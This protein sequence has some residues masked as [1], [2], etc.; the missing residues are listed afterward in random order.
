MSTTPA[1]HQDDSPGLAVVLGG[2][3]GIGAALAEG[4]RQQGHEVLA[5][6]RR[7]EPALDY[8]N[9]TSVARV[10][11]AVAAE[12]ARTAA[13]RCAAWWWPPASCTKQ[14]FSPSEAGPTST[15]LRCSACFW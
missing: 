11:Q 4:L 9:D 8:A 6:G 7:T 2:T 3:G 15:L 5:L 13:C 10:A 14:R 1:P 12:L